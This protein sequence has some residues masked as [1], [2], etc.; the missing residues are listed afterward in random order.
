MSL[1]V[2]FPKHGPPLVSLVSAEFVNGHIKFTPKD[3]AHVELVHYPRGD[4]YR[5]DHTIARFLARQGASCKLYGI[6]DDAFS[7]A[8]VDQWLDFALKDLQVQGQQ[9]VDACKYLNLHLMLRT[10]FAGYGLTLADIA[11]WA[12]LKAHPE[13]SV[14][15]GDKALQQLMRWFNYCDALPEFQ[16]VVNKYLKGGNQKGQTDTGVGAIKKQTSKAKYAS[17]DGAV[18]GKVVTR[19]PPEPSGYLHIGHVKAALLNNYYARHYN[20]KLILR[21]DDTNPTKENVGFVDSITKDAA[22][23]GLI[24]DTITYTSNYFDKIL[25]YAEVMINEGK[26]YVDLTPVAEMQE[27]RKH[28]VESKYRSN[29]VEENKRL[30]DEMKQGTTEGAKAVLRAK[31]DMTSPNGCLRD[32]SIYRVVLSPPHHRT[33]ARYKVYPIYDFACPIVDSLEGVT[34]ALRSSEY[35]DRNEQYRWFLNALNLSHKPEISDFSRLNF[36]YTL[37]SK[38]KLQW[39]VDGGFVEGWDSAAFPTVQGILRRGLTVEALREFILSQGSS[40]K[41]TLQGMEKLWALNKQY[42]DRIIP[43]FTAVG[44][45]GRVP[46]LLSNGPS[47]GPVFKSVPKHKQNASLGEKVVTYSH[48]IFIEQEDAKV[49]KEGEE[50]TLMDWGNAIVRRI[51]VTD[52]VV[53]SMEGELHLEGDFKTTKWKLTW[54]ADV[55]DLIPV[56]LL[57]YDYL[58]TKPKLEKTDNFE[59]F[60]NPKIIHTTEALGDPNLRLVQKGDRMQLERRGYFICDSPFRDIGAVV[61]PLVLIL[62][63][64]GRATTQSHLSSKVVLKGTGT[65]GSAQAE[66]SKKKTKKAGTSSTVPEEQLSSSKEKETKGN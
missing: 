19:F 65:A 53:T 36:M 4:V 15:S 34:H 66:G 2:H 61:Q 58:I 26:A 13:W 14:V 64:D 23:L 62:I 6:T 29:T 44:K 56:K 37:L 50:V 55:P 21:F 17:L 39:F 33:G 48:K 25:E 3:Q 16:T 11:V 30:W 35:H 57:E 49:L 18:E 51:H 5:G 9:F 46:F 20:G 27:G 52:N 40:K 12:T 45:E 7:T 28:M 10:F 47:N 63:P 60:V 38:R 31:I 59:Q 32:P 22:T 43:R 8:N 1:V 54:L 42:I 41:D 24:P